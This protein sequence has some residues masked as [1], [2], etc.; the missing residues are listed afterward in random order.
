MLKK[1]RNCRAF[2][3]PTCA[4]LAAVPAT[5]QD[6]MLADIDGGRVE[7]VVSGPEDSEPLLLLHG[8]M[9][10]TAL[11]LVQ[12]EPAL[13]GYRTIRMH[14]RGYAGSSP[15]DAPLSVAERAADAAGLLDAL[16]VERAH[17]AGHSAGAAV[18]L[19]L[20]ADAPER[21]HSLV[22]IDPA[23]PPGFFEA[24]AAAGA[25]SGANAATAFAGPQARRRAAAERVAA[26]DPEGAVEAFSSFVFGADWR[27][28]YDAVP[29]GF[30]QAVADALTEFGGGEGAPWAFS[31]AQMQAIAEPV[32]VLGA[33]ESPLWTEPEAE[34]LAAMF[35]AGEA[36]VVADADH[37]LIVQKP[38]EVAETV[39]AF[40]GRHPM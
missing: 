29:G 32:L 40:I 4:A 23:P 9:L 22:L 14:A 34:T 17:V 35:E 12:A 1:H 6:T 13:D 38:E 39:A 33:T 3:I 27:D 2:I 20:A 21:V 31:A 25:I 8:G 11:A 28:Y 26:G 16:G 15:L 37:A 18:A 7:Y 24:Q 10:A 19:Q 36:D 5:A 30:G